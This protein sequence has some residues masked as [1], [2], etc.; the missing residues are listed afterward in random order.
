MRITSSG[1]VGIQTVDNSGDYTQHTISAPLH[2][3]QKTASQGYG[4]AIQG[5]SNTA[6]ARLG[7]GNANC[8]FGTRDKVLDIGFDS[9]TDFIFSRTTKDLI[10]GVDSSEVARFDTQGNFGIGASGSNLNAR[11]VRGFS[12]NKGLVIETAQP[13]IQLVDTDNTGRYFTMAYEQS[14]KTVY[15]HNQSNGPFRFD[16]NG[17][18]RME[19]TGSGNLVIK[20][21]VAASTNSQSLP[22][23]LSFQG[24]GWDSDSGSDPI[25]GRITFAG[26]Y[27]GTSAGAHS[28]GGVIPKLEFG[29]VNSGDSGSTSESLTTVLSVEGAQHDLTGGSV[30]IAGGQNTYSSLGIGTGGTNSYSET[31]SHHQNSAITIDFP[32]ADQSYGA[33]RWRSHGNMEQFFGVVQE[34]ASGQ[35]DWVWQGFDGSAYAE[36]MRLSEEGLLS[37]KYGIDS[38]GLYINGLPSSSTKG[39]LLACG[40][41]SATVDAILFRDGSNDNC[42]N[43]TLNSS[44]NTTNYGATSDYRLK[45][46]EEIISD[47]IQRIKKLKP[48]RFNFITAPDQTMDGF[49]AHE[50]AEHIPEAVSGKKDEMDGDEIKPQ[51]VDYGKV[52]PLLVRA[53]QELIV[54]V[55]ELEA[56]VESLTGRLDELEPEEPEQEQSPTVKERVNSLEAR[57]NDLENG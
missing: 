10:I 31:S 36:R 37:I 13:A 24:F 39:I 34:G 47:G 32:N 44:A 7:I 51:N 17:V 53:V 4:L 25:E 30:S 41:S 43:I 38:Y 49:F 18:E 29:I 54:N 56:K 26:S 50:L 20:T 19:L 2:I 11:I 14:A 1:F 42:G 33:I 40:S 27:G 35:G 23:Y 21:A 3:L 48:Y 52:T 57:V 6:G 46:N 22:G 5:N 8:N 12:A 28:G 15:M 45:E 9:N 55:E 16:T